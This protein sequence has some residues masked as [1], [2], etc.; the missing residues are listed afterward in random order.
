MSMRATP[1]PPPSRRIQE[2][3]ADC[4]HLAAAHYENFP[5]A[6]W[7]L[8]A[9]LRGPV[10]AIYCFARTAD[11]L[12]DEDP[13]PAPLR[14]VALEDMRAHLLQLDDP[15]QETE[16]AWCALA[17]TLR[18][19][20]LPRTPFLHLLDAFQQDLVQ[21]RYADFAAVMHYCRRSAQ[22]VG[23]LLLH[24]TDSA[25]PQTLA[26]S[27]ALCTAL[28][29][30]NFY[31]DLTQD[32]EEHGRIY[33][34]QDEMA[35]FGVTDAQIAERRHDAALQRLMTYQ[36]QR[37]DRLLRASAPLGTALSGR[38]ALEIRAILLSGA[39]TLWRLQ[40]QPHPFSRP[41]L[42][43]RDRGWILFHSLF[44]PRRPRSPALGKPTP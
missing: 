4:R 5:V 16:P 27:D 1:P 34:P 13:R 39:R 37:A 18:D 32:L 25:T 3:Y 8:P 23:R 20:A 31:Q 22:P 30:L 40:Q 14:H 11:D 43:T 44:P 38:F 36:Y 29:L 17:A 28:Q 19:H 10:A 26:W 24:L 6:S 42:T 12:A 15:L 9:R 7:L 21:S 2:A 33:L 35:R 41:R